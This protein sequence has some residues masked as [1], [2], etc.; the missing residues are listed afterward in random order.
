MSQLHYN[1]E[2]FSN[3]DGWK[4]I[5][6]GIP[7]YNVGNNPFYNAYQQIKGAFQL[8]KKI[9]SGDTLILSSEFIF[10]RFLNWALLDSLIKKAK[11]TILIHAGCSS[12]FHKVMSETLL[13]RQ[14]KI[15]DT[16]NDICPF[17]ERNWLGIKRTIERIDKIVPFTAIY[18][19]S[20]KLYESEYVTESLNF[21]I[22]FDSPN[23]E[24]GSSFVKGYFH[25]VNRLG[26][27]GTQYLMDMSRESAILN[28]Y[29][30]MAGKLPFSEYL[31]VL[32]SHS[33][34]ID[35]LFANGYGMNGALAFSYGIPVIYGFHDVA[36]SSYFSGEFAIPVEILNERNSDSM[37]IEKLLTKYMN[38][39]YRPKDVFD[40]G[41][42]RHDHL[43]IT[44][45]FIEII[46]E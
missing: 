5:N 35:Q 9:S 31:E 44:K 13:C 27:K 32:R 14:C 42:N 34:L 37:R 43:K 7:L 33:C 12:E 2:I 17:D 26:F 40:F 19:E 23:I 4:K 6:T 21:P 25:G 41:F 36:K 30:T 11:K 16:K 46:N 15:F 18:E 22:V 45:R 28:E 10:N 8:S 24:D 38:Y 3:G 29:I 20:S 1:S 39:E